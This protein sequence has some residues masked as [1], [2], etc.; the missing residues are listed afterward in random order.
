VPK[1]SQIIELGQINVSSGGNKR[2]E[3]DLPVT[4]STNTQL[5][6]RLLSGNTTN[7]KVSLVVKGTVI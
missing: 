7:L 3:I 4:P 6:C 1:P 2:F 5:A